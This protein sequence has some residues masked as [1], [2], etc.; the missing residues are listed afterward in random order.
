MA[1][2]SS[3]FRQLVNPK[4]IAAL[5]AELEGDKAQLTELF[6]EYRRMR[7]RLAVLSEGIQRQETVLEAV[8]SALPPDGKKGG[9]PGV[10]R[11]EAGMTKREIATEILKESLQPLFPRQVREIAIEKGW[12]P[13]THAASNQLSVAMSKAARA[14]IFARDREGRYSLAEQGK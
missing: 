14:G 11:H 13:D 4:S 1:R 6:D 10:L 3:V 12:L 9:S 8:R 7:E 5:E 2:P